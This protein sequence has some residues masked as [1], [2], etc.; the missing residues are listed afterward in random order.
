MKVRLNLATSSLESSRR[1]AA[2]AAVV[3]GLGVLAMC[4]LAWHAASVWRA[5]AASMAEQQQLEADMTQLRAQRAE[6]EAF[7]NQP[8]NVQRRD[9]AAFLNGLIARR[10]FPWI[11][12]FMALERSLPA[13]VRVVSIEPRLVEGH[14]ELRFAIGAASDEGKLNFLKALEGS[15]EFSQIE[16]LSETRSAKPADTDRVLVSL[17]ARYSAT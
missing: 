12:V 15:P 11:N 6:I 13:G 1:F 17:E 7:F 4:L 10:A 2:G 14:L 3:G 9:R 16:V 5:N 8:Q